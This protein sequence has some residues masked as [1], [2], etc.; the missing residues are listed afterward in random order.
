MK[1]GGKSEIFSV[2]YLSGFD[3]FHSDSMQ[4]EHNL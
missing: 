2:K 4:S 1:F 3:K